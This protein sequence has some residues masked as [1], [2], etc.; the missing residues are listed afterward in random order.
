MRILVVEDEKKTAGF[1]RKGLVE[2]G[3]QVEV[4]ANGREGLAQALAEDY[5]LAILDVL[6]PDGDGWSILT[7]LRQAGKATPVL[8]L[9]ALDSVAARVKGLELGADDYLVKPFAFSE[10]LARIRSVLRRSQQVAALVRIGD[11]EIDTGR[12]RARRAGQV[13][14]LTPKEFLLLTLL[15]RHV[16]ETLSRQLIGEHVWGVRCAGDSNVVDVHV[17]RLRAKLD[18]PFEQKLLHTVRGLGYVLQER[19]VK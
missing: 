16:G 4:A 15:A 2:H 3:F 7:A 8:F 5:D 11:L 9:T 6:V 13:L 18:D 14:E 12:Q 17:R 10:L 1:V 19:P